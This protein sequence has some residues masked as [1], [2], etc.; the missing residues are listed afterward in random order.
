MLASRGG[1]RTRQSGERRIDN[2]PV[3]GKNVTVGDETVKG[4]TITVEGETVA[5]YVLLE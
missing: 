4:A 1:A 3:E 2:E 5:M